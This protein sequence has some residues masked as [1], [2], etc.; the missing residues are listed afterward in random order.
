MHVVFLSLFLGKHC[1]CL[2]RKNRDQSCFLGV[3]DANFTKLQNV[4]TQNIHILKVSLGQMSFCA[5]SVYQYN[6]L[7]FW[8]IFQIDLQC[9]KGLARQECVGRAGIHQH[10]GI[11]RFSFCGQHGL[12]E[13]PR[14]VPNVTPCNTSSC[15]TPS[16]LVT[17]DKCFT[18]LI[19]IPRI[20]SPLIS[21][22]SMSNS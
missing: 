12:H 2:Y 10:D 16:P 15:E 3:V 1:I 20:V 18:P 13:N 19:S 21:V 22:S 14:I 7:I 4:G 5:L 6:S 9:F 17:S 8:L 11:Q